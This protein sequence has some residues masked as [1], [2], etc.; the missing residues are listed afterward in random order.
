MSG[1]QTGP[2]GAHSW[3]LRGGCGAGMGVAI[4]CVLGAPWRG[5]SVEFIPLKPNTTS[6]QLSRSPSGP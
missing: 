4:P 6:L 2:S 1:A 3:P 5:D